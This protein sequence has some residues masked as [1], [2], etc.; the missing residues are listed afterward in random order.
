MVVIAL[1]C[2]QDALQRVPPATVGQTYGKVDWAGYGPALPF[3]GVPLPAGEGAVSEE[4][5]TV[6]SIAFG[7]LARVF[8]FSLPMNTARNS[9][10]SAS[11]L[12]ATL[13]SCSPASSSSPV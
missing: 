12:P 2:V 4:G 5:R 7:V 1:S 13:S 9:V 11:D 8:P 10:C 6:P 3:L